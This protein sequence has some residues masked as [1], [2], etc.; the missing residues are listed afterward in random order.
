MNF[1]IN[2]AKYLKYEDE[3]AEWLRRWTANPLCFARVGSNPTFVGGVLLIG[4]IGC[5]FESF[6]AFPVGSRS[7]KVFVQYSE[8]G[9]IKATSLSIFY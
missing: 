4:A 2:L 9:L 8:F 5:V 3:V 6:L 1:E 7:L